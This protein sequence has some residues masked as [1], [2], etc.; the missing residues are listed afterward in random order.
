MSPLGYSVLRMTASDQSC[1]STG[2]GVGER[3]RALRLEAGLTQSQLAI[4]LGTTQS[5]IARLER[6]LHR[7]SL[8]TINRVAAA[9][10][11]ETVVLFQQK[12][13]A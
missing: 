10:G 1:E 11:C 9:L 12:Q 13:G 6:G 8:E 5:A 7:T 3:L 4:R 2:T